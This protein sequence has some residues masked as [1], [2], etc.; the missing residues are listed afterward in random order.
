MATE[1]LIVEL[2]ASTKKLD[3]KLETT[4]NK[5][6][7]LSTSTKK[8]DDRLKNIKKA[9]AIASKAI[10]AVAAAGAAAGAALAAATI[11]AVSFAKEIQIAAN[12]SGETVEKIQ[13]LAFAT[14]TVGISMEK[15]G[16]ISKDT[17][18]KVGEFLTSGGGGFQDFADV[19]GLT[20]DEAAK[21][22][23][24]FESMSG[25]EV[26]Q[27]MVDKMEAAHVSTEK[28]SFALEGMASD[29]TDLIPLLTN[30]GE[31]VNALTGE[32][33]TLGVT[34]NQVD[35]D[36]IKRIGTEIDALGAKT[37]GS[38]GKLVSVL[39]EDIS[40]VVEFLNKSSDKVGEWVL[41]LVKAWQIIVVGANAAISNLFRESEIAA[42]KAMATMQELVNVDTSAL[43]EEI[44]A[45]ELTDEQR[46]AFDI[47]Y[48]TDQWNAAREALKEYKGEL[49]TGVLEITVKKGNGKKPPTPEE[50][51]AAQKKAE[52]ARL[53]NTRKFIAAASIL[54]SALLEDNKA[55][56]A[57]LIVADTAAG[58]MMAFRS[59]NN[60][61][62]AYANAAIIVAT[63]IAQL[64]NL[65]SASKGG[66]SMSS[67]G[68]GG[69]SSA[70]G[71]QQQDFQP[72]TSQLDVTTTS[73]EGQQRII[74]EFATDSGDDFLDALAGGLEQR[75]RDGR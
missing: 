17:N 57:G 45:L 9:G 73:E 74:V 39:N 58:V 46:D 69:G 52:I 13:A 27:E 48:L 4:S 5:I 49:G 38:S 14:G 56:N 60:P 16:D 21:L 29:T 8:A 28:M 7:G 31:R 47:S 64:A 34:L 1:S 40:A 12:R 24:E 59:A 68:G 11:Q 22:A 30:G 63:G 65:S 41:T 10:S 61:Y 55:V 50:E 6:D 15:L 35:I 62:E 43:R 32:F 25:L 75:T 23:T 72:D 51:T 20:A 36:R 71:S 67:G 26:L 54:N 2:D 42:K 18:E 53:G 19:L 3:A 70:A 44:A 33:E 37:R 66:G